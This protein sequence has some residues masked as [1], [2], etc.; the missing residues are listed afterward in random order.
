M[1]STN[2]FLMYMYRLLTWYRKL[3][4]QQIIREDVNKIGWIVANT[5]LNLCCGR[6]Q[7][8]RKVE[9]FEETLAEDEIVYHGI[10]GDVGPSKNVPDPSTSDLNPSTCWDDIGPSQAYINITNP[11]SS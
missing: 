7:D 3:G 1:M 4:K 11:T 9:H 8:F 5:M 2:L 10:V 6:L